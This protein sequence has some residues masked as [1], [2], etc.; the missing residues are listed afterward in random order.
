MDDSAAASEQ[1]NQTYLELETTAAVV[2][3]KQS[4]EDV[5]H[6]TVAK[7]LHNCDP[8]TWKGLATVRQA[9]ACR[10]R[11]KGKK[12]KVNDTTDTVA[13]A[14]QLGEHADNSTVANA[15]LSYD[16][17]DPSAG[18]GHATVGLA[19]RRSTRKRYI[20][21]KYDVAEVKLHALIAEEQNVENGM[22]SGSKE[23]VPRGKCSCETC[24]KL[25]PYW[26]R[27]KQHM[28]SH[29][30]EGLVHCDICGRGFSLPNH[31]SHHMKATHATYRPYVCGN[32]GASFA[33]RNFLNVHM[34][35]HQ[36]ETEKEAAVAKMQQVIHRCR[37]CSQTFSSRYRKYRH[38]AKDHPI[39]PRRKKKPT[40]CSV[41]PICGKSLAY[42]L[43][44]HMR[45]HTG[46]RPYKCPT[47]D[48]AF[49]QRTSLLHHMTTHS[50]VKSHTC[51]Q[52]GKSFRLHTLLRQHMRMHADPVDLRH[53]CP[54]CGKRFHVPIQLRDHLLL[55]TGERPHQCAVC[56]RQFRLRRELVRHERYH[57]ASDDAAIRCKVCGLIVSNLKRHMLVHSGERPH[58]CEHCGKAF[59]RREHLRA[60]CLRLHNV[61]LPT[62]NRM[63]A[64][65]VPLD[66]CLITEQN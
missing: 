17:S 24:G 41:C 33:E 44:V 61:Q 46:E 36:S 65:T 31:L 40:K 21:A 34:I 42:R 25:F 58:I 4:V 3:K 27:L 29:H 51:S 32:C 49:L 60:H 52:C 20:P 2:P 43:S 66:S 16:I 53:V 23:V 10:R 30:R 55:H 5:N 22:D 15:S 57:T 19:C 11:A 59:R 12:T 48:K 28:E 14:K 47:C 8:L 63:K 35:A 54:L 62:C 38:M 39:R 26:R 45:L 13:Q 18:K 9:H 37:K 1:V 50:D 7:N 64:Q 6:A 56:G